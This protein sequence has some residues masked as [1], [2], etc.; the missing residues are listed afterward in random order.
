M[1]QNSFLLKVHHYRTVHVCNA[2]FLLPALFPEL[3]LVMRLP[4]SACQTSLVHC[5]APQRER[6]GR[7]AGKDRLTREKKESQRAFSGYYW[8]VAFV[9]LPKNESQKCC[10]LTGYI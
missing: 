8:H 3:L 1:S 4:L 2:F 9:K 7:G 6:Q 5:I 10:L